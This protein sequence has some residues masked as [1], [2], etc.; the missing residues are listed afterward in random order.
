MESTTSVKADDLDY[1]DF[2]VDK[3]KTR[4]PIEAYSQYARVFN[5]DSKEWRF[6]SV[7]DRQVFLL[8]TQHWFNVKLRAEGYVF[9]NDVYET[10]GLNRVE[11]YE[12]RIGWTYSLDRPTGDNYI[13]FGL[14]DWKEFGSKCWLGDKDAIL[15]DFNVD[16]DILKYL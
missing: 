14:F 5:D 10:L 12:G 9:L 8:N 1:I 4:G 16:G 2:L 15:L 7:A 6:R 13:D 11:E 3:V